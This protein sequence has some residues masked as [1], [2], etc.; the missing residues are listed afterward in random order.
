MHTTDYAF[1]LR[2]LHFYYEDQLVLDNIHLNIEKNAATALI[3]PSGSGKSTLLRCLNLIY[4]LYPHHHATGE[5]LY[6]GK[7]L[8]HFRGDLSRLRA[9]IG[10]VFQKPS[11]FPMSIHDNIAFAVRLH[12][13]IGKKEL[14]DRIEVALRHAALWDEVKDKLHHRASQLSGGQQQRLCIARTIAIQPEILL[15]DEPTAALDPISTKQIEHLIL[16]LKKH[17]T[18]ILV[19]HNLQQARRVTD[20]TAFLQK[21]HLIEYNSTELYFTQPVTPQ[22]KVYL[23]NG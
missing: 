2:E 10:M 7:N 20:F 6:D 3:G 14:E 4:K 9:R 16:E 5:I 1:R 11:P 19:T 17:Y 21:G 15:L 23:A 22:S 13:K 8:I 18:I 12:E